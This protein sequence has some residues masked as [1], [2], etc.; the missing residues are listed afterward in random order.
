MNCK[1]VIWKGDG[2]GGESCNGEK[3][4]MKGMNA[5]GFTTF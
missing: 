2:Q 4:Q 3:S 5:K 1:G